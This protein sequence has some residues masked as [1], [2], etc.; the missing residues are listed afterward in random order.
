MRSLSGDKIKYITVDTADNQRMYF[1][2]D[3]PD[4]MTFNP[5]EMANLVDK[6]NYIDEIHF[7]FAG[8][9]VL[10]RKLGFVYK[11]HLP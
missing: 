11:G 3:Y 1:I 7:D 5:E 6:D 10:L 2:S 9:A 8:T 4:E